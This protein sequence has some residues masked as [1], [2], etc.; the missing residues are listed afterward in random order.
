MQNT[1]RACFRA[2]ISR[3]IAIRRILGV[4]KEILQDGVIG[5]LVSPK[6]AHMRA[7]LHRDKNVALQSYETGLLSTFSE[8]LSSG[9]RH[10]IRLWSPAMDMEW[11]GTGRFFEDGEFFSGFFLAR[12]LSRGPGHGVKT[13]YDDCDSVDAVDSRYPSMLPEQPRANFETSFDL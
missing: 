13:E 1:L 10:W 12:S 3:W 7:H 4:M 5:S 9:L 2:N 8:A 6:R 11:I